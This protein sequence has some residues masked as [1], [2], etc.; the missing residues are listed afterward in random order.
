MLW[1]PEIIEKLSL[2]S[3]RHSS[4]S[5]VGFRKN[6]LPNLNVVA[7]PMAVSAGTFEGMALRGRSSRVYEKWASLS[8]VDEMVLKRFTLKLLIF[9]GPSIPFAE[10]P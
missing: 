8:F 7:N 6:G 2:A 5:I 10:F 9:D 1:L 3:V 4:S